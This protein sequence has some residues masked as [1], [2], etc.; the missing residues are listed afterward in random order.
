MVKLRFCMLKYVT[1]MFRNEDMI[2]ISYEHIRI[3]INISWY[4]LLL[5]QLYVKLSIYL[6]FIFFINKTHDVEDKTLQLHNNNDSSYYIS[7][8]KRGPITKMVMS[9]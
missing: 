4:I 3:R 6:N 1:Y 2:N 7:S 9:H 5:L 8:G